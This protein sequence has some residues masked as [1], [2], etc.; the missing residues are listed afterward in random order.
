MTI[1]VDDLS[2]PEIATL[3]HEHFH[4]LRAISPPESCH[5][6]ELDKLRTPDVTVWSAWDGNEILGCGALKEIEPGHGEIKSMRTRTAHLRKGVGTAVLREIICE[7]KRRA[8]RRLSLETGAGPDFAAARAMYQKNG[9]KSCGPFGNYR[10]DP[11]SS[12]FTM[13]LEPSRH[14]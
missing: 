10:D 8:Y 14:D 3:L 13:A 5:V 1:K 6:F 11:N 9:F 7:A 2:G 12:F 4:A